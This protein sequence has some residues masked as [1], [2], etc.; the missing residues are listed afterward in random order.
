VKFGVKMGGE[1]GIT[2]TK[3]T[4]EADLKTTTMRDRDG[5]EGTSWPGMSDSR[6]GALL[7]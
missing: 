2:L 1:S 4:A 3:G 7:A 6:L 5:R